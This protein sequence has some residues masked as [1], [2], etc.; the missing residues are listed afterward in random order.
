MVNMAI[1]WCLTPPHLFGANIP[2]YRV[3]S[4]KLY[5]DR[6]RTRKRP[7]WIRLRFLTLMAVRVKKMAGVR[8]FS[9]RGKRSQPETRALDPIRLIYSELMFQHCL[10]NIQLMFQHCLE[11]I[12][13]K[14]Q[15]LCYAMYGLCFH[16]TPPLSIAP[17]V[18]RPN[19]CNQWSSAPCFSV[20]Y[21]HCL[22]LIIL[23]NSIAHVTRYDS[24]TPKAN[25]CS[26]ACVSIAVFPVL[27]YA[28]H[29]TESTESTVGRILL[30]SRTSLE[31]RVFEPRHGIAKALF[32]ITSQRSQ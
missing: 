25:R 8:C 32:L 5:I 13:V 21:H 27:C 11:N 10:E 26:V 14:T 9:N 23:Y 3:S 19:G 7:C 1:D 22:L 2:R 30:F 15:S 6:G 28:S 16:R 4:R 31:L 29:N 12:Q 20:F 24:T 17:R 18:R